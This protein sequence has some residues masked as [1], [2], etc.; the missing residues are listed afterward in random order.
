MLFCSAL[1]A[2]IAELEQEQR[3]TLGENDQV[4][5]QADSRVTKR[6]ILIYY[7][8]ED[9][10]ADRMARGS[11]EVCVEGSV[12]CFNTLMRT[13]H[14]EEMRDTQYAT[15]NTQYAIRIHP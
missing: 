2:L 9:T 12:L 6:G 5:C 11:S 4:R 10:L 3:A 15:R 14:V 7:L 8:F 13:T 1:T